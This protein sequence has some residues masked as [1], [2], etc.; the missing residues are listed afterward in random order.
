MAT[1]K[2]TSTTFTREY[3]LEE[4]DKAVIKLRVSVPFYLSI[5]RAMDI[6]NDTVR[7]LEVER[8][9][10]LNKQGISRQGR[11]IPRGPLVEVGQGTRRGGLD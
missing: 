8:D 10:Y 6:F 1:V 2:T 5:E 3:S 7:A 4:D 9:E 11:L